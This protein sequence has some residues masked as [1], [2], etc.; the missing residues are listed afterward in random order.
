MNQLIAITQQWQIYL[1]ED[2]RK[3]VNLTKPTQAKISVKKKKI[4]IE[5]VESRFLQAAGCLSKVKPTTKI[6]IDNVRDYVD[7]SKW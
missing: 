4:I 2:I 7:Y 6:D 3:A 1:P 5:P